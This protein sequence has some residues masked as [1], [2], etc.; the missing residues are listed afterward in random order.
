MQ[1]NLN[2]DQ[3][4]FA[5]GLT[6]A[7]LLDELDVKGPLAVEINR[8]ICP[9]KVHGETVIQPDDVVEIVTIVGGG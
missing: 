4:E 2:G 7:E 8:Q 1:I 5:E 6:V 3:R 9:K